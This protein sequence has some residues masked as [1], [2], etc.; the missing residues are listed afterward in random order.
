[1][2]VRHATL[3]DLPAILALTQ[4]VE[5]GMT[6]LPHDEQVLQARLAC[7]Q[8]TLAQCIHQDE[9]RYLFVLELDNKIVGVSAIEVAVGKTSPFYDFRLTTEV[10]SSRQLQ[11]YHSLE[12]LFLSNDYTGASELCSLYLAPEY[13]KGANGK[14]LS[15][16]RL[17]FIAGFKEYFAGRLIAEM[18][19]YFDST[20]VSPFW[21]HFSSKFFQSD[22]AKVDYLIGTGDKTFIAELM[23]RFPIYLDLM[24]QQARAVIGQVHP[25]TASALKLLQDEGLRFDG[26]ID[27]I[28]GGP[29]VIARLG[30]LR[31]VQDSVLLPVS[32]GSGDVPATRA[33]L[34]SNDEYAGYRASVVYLP[35]VLG[36]SV[37]L[38][39]EDFANLRL[40]TGASV[41][42]LPLDPS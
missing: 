13:R 40:T 26:H 24:P 10:H 22:F 7:T 29:K 39:A 5:V 21:A 3:D 32:V 1:M 9:Q 33:Y 18:R 16:A 11:V 35:A 27:I 42:L 12:A 14:L 38:S 25:N 19:G 30:D 8:D 20:G 2:I 36:D 31:A 23:P 4:T 41:R 17:L 6:S 15:K 28:D 34:V 37:R